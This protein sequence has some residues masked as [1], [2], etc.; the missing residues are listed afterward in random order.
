MDVF[1]GFEFTQDESQEDIDVN[2]QKFDAFCVEKTNF[3]YER[4]LF[5]TCVQGEMDSFYTFLFKIR[6]LMDI[7]FIL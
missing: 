6:I 7:H 4:Y 2:L 5:R 3:T 1:E